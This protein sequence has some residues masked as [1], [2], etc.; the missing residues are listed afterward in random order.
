MSR[1]R[2][3]YFARARSLAGLPQEALPVVTGE[4]IAAIRTRLVALHPEIA[5]LVGV[6]RFARNGEFARDDEAVGDGDEIAVLPP[7]SGGSD[8]AL[9]V[10]RDVA[11][12]EASRLIATDGAGAIATFTGIVRGTGDHSSEPVRY[13][14]YEAYPPLAVR[15]MARILGESRARFGLVDAAILHRTGRL[16]VGETAVDIAVSAPHRAEAF[17]GCRY[18]IDEVKTRVPIWKRETTTS[19]SEWVDCHP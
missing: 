1:V 13:L 16:V 2:V 7:V 3:L 17:D 15:E 9:L 10:E 19:G 12:G 11:P 6:C 5:P 8:K 4:T 18:V 14:D